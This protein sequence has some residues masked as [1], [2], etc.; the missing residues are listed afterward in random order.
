[1]RN[2]VKNMNYYVW[3]LFGIGLLAALFYSMYAIRLHEVYRPVAIN[4][5]N[6]PQDHAKVFVSPVPYDVVEDYKTKHPE[7]PQYDFG[8][9]NT[10][11]S[12]VNRGFLLTVK[13]AHVIGQ[14]SAPDSKRM[15]Y[16]VRREHK[17]DDGAWTQTDIVTMEPQSG[18][19]VQQPVGFA[20]G[21]TVEPFS[22]STKLCGFLSDHE[23]VYTTVVNAD[24]E[25]VYQAN[26]FDLERKTVTP[27]IELFRYEPLGGSW[28]APVLYHAV[29]T[30][31]NKHLFVRDSI[32][33]M[34]HYSLSTGAKK[35]LINGTQEVRPGER[36][37]LPN[38]SLAIYGLNR[39]QSD[40]SWI[41]LNEGAVRQP[42][43]A[44]QGFIDPGTDAKGKVMYYNF[45]YD[46]APEH[47]MSFDNRTLLA[48]SGVQ[49]ADFQGKK[50]QRFALSKESKE[51]LE[52][53][54]YSESKNSVLLHKYVTAVNSKGQPYK[55]TLQWLT[56]D[57]ATGAMSE[58]SR[59]DVPDGWDRSEVV[60]GTISTSPSTSASEEQVFVNFADR[61]Y[62]MSHWKTRQVALKQ[63]DDVITFVDEPSKRVFVSSFTRPD[64]LVAA[65][66]YKKYNWDNPEF[67]WLS[68]G[69]MARHQTLPE[70]DKLFFFQI[71]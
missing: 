25:W 11:K 1:M 24:Q 27:L 55:K 64:L 46:R 8:T 62:Y 17:Q 68:G 54:G 36:F 6:A 14:L 34:T 43:A 57:I 5:A 3:L 49:L 66:S 56:G 9:L 7:L 38:S 40:M 33:G 16:L 39:Y 13:Q 61:L 44:E 45:T 21:R 65:F 51:C 28:N 70:G 47:L 50:L 35:Q 2:W 58:L 12:K 10:V 26:V 30:S 20:Y 18:Q 52:F 67:G 63:E 19:M 23:V 53:G 48:S 42:F 59:V 37:E 60:F 15:V 32:G 41:D 69:W 22:E 29:L 31:D 71:N 4:A